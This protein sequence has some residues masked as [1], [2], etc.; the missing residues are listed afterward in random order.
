[1]GKTDQSALEGVVN[2][3]LLPWT[4]EFSFYA[5]V[6]TFV[7][8]TLHLISLLDGYF[9]DDPYPGYGSVGK[10][11]NENKKE[12]NLIRENLLNEVGLLFKKETQK[13][14]EKRGGLDYRHIEKLV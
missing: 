4:V 14:S 7:G 12:I 2:N 1:M 8:I 5:F 3:V 6:L 10:G 11:R 13:I 9:F